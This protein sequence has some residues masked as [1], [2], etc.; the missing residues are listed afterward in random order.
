[1]K[2][3]LSIFALLSAFSYAGLGDFL[4]ATGKALTETCDKCNDEQVIG[5]HAI[6]DKSTFHRCSNFVENCE[7]W[8]KRGGSQGNNESRAYTFQTIKNE[9][10]RFGLILKE[11][12]MQ[13][14]IKKAKLLEQAKQDSIKKAKQDSSANEIYALISGGAE[15]NLILNKCAEHQNKFLNLR[16]CRAIQD[17]IK[18]QQDI[19]EITALLK[20]DKLEEVFDKCKQ[21]EFGPDKK[22]Y[23]ECMQ[24]K[25]GTNDYGE[26]IIKNSSKEKCL[27]ECGPVDEKI[28]NLCEKQLIAK[29]KK[30]PKNK[31]TSSG[32][33]N[34]YYDCDKDENCTEVMGYI[35]SNDGNAILVSTLPFKQTAM[36]QISGYIVNKQKCML[37][38]NW[39]LLF[40]GHAKYLGEKTYTTVLGA[41]NSVPNYQLL[42]CGD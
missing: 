10:L 31:I 1:M 8:T 25:F 2:K 17:S 6:S 20:A 40:S 19:T 39:Q 26:R 30:T 5:C 41:R 27:N 29:V 38:P 28:T 34:I 36:I 16:E 33:A 9:V 4:K 23:D 32:L 42:W 22:C 37:R 18:Y 14:S 35:I 21:F 7:C 3:I 15:I 11:E 24:P 12:A 13:D